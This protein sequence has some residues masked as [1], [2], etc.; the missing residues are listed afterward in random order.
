MPALSSP[1]NDV[2]HRENHNPHHIY[3]MPV[4]RQYVDAIGMLL[5]NIPKQRERHYGGETN[6]AHNH[7]KPVQ[8]DQG[9][10]GCAEQVRADRQSISDK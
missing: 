7:V 3:E 10:V 8:A 6:Q 9:I 2:N 5:L 4:E 1:S